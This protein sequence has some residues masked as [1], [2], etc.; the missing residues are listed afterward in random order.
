MR[1]V[2]RVVGEVLAVMVREEHEVERESSLLLKLMGFER[3]EIEVA[4]QALGPD[5][6]PEGKGVKLIIATHKHWEGAPSEWFL[7]SDETQVTFRND[8]SI[9]LVLFEVEDQPDAQSVRN[10]QVLHDGTVL[11]QASDGAGLK[12]RFLVVERCWRVAASNDAI[13]LPEDLFTVLEEIFHVVQKESGVLALRAWVAFV[14]K[15]CDALR[16]ERRAVSL[17]QIQEA[18]VR[19]LPHLHL[20]SDDGL[21]GGN[22]GQVQKRLVLNVRMAGM[23]APNG[24]ELDEEDLERRIAAAS[25]RNS[26]NVPLDESEQDDWRSKCRAVLSRRNSEEYSNVPLA[27]WEQIFAKEKESKVGLGTRIREHFSAAH[28]DRLSEYEDQ[29]L[30]TPLDQQ[31][32]VA[33]KALLDLEAEDAGQRPLID[34]LSKPLRKA[35]E[36]LASP[37]SPTVADPLVAVLRHLYSDAFQEYE[38][39]AFEQLELSAKEVAGGRSLYSLALFRFLYGRT[40]LEIVDDATGD[41][42]IPFRVD[43][44]LTGGRVDF[45]ELHRELY[46]ESQVG[47]DDEGSTSIDDEVEYQWEPL[48][49]QIVA[50]PGDQIL[51]RFSWNPQ[52]PGGPAGLIAFLRVVLNTEVSQVAASAGWSDLEDWC[53][54]LA[55]PRNGLSGDCPTPGLEGPV[56]D[57]MLLRAEAFKDWG[58]KGIDVDSLTNYVGR[59]QGLQDR[60]RAECIPAQ[61]IHPGLEGFLDME[62][63]RLGP[64]RV[65]LLASHPLRL[66]WVAEY[67]RWARI[68]LKD[69][70]CGNFKLNPEVDELFFGWLAEQSP[71]GQPPILCPGHQALSISTREYG[72]HEEYR[73]IV[74]DDSPSED[75]VSSID[76]ESVKALAAVVKRYVEAHPHKSDGLSVLFISRDGEAD[77]VEKLIKEVR[78]SGPERFV[79]TVHVV[80]PKSAHEEIVRR[81]EDLGD[82]D[83]SHENLLPQLRT[84]LHPIGI[85]DHPDRARDLGLDGQID[86]AIVPNLLGRKTAVNAR[87]QGP[88]AGEF[89]PLHDD[90]THDVGGEDG[91]RQN[92]ARAFLPDAGDALLEGWSSLQVWRKMWSRIG[93][94]DREQIDYFSLQVLF[95]ASAE[96]FAL[97]HDWSHWV[98]TLDPYVTRDQI[99]ASDRRP[100]II[101]VQPKVGKNGRYTLVVSSSTGRE[102]VVGRLQRRIVQALP[103]GSA[104]HAK[105]MA[106]RLYACGRDFAP[107][108]LLR[109]LGLGRTTQEILGLVVAREVVVERRPL[110]EDDVFEAWLSLDELAHWFGGP[111]RQRADLLRVVGKRANG[112]LALR[113]QIV[114]AKF[115]EYEHAGRG[116]SQLTRT[117]DVLLPA[118]ELVDEKAPYADGDHWRR[119]LLLAIEQCAGR[120]AGHPGTGGHYVRSHD[121]HGRLPDDVRAAI[122]EG[123]YLMDGMEAILCT[124]GAGDESLEDSEELTPQESHTWFRVGARGFRRVLLA[125]GEGAPVG[126]STESDRSIDGGE[127]ASLGSDAATSES[128][129]TEY[130]PGLPSSGS[131]DGG[132]LSGE[133][134][135]DEMGT[136]GRGLGAECLEGRFQQVLN[137]FS[138][139]KIPVERPE[140]YRPLEGP[141]F[142][143][144]RL[145]PGKGVRSDKIIG[146]TR[147][148]KLK[149]ELPEHLEIRGFV[150]RGSVVF[151]IPKED[152]ERYF[153]KTS[154]LWAS[155]DHPRVSQN[156]L[157]TPIGEN[158]KGDPVWLDFGDADSPHLLIGG[159]TGSGKSVALESILEGLC[160][161]HGPKLLRLLLIDPKGTELLGFEERAH[162]EGEIGMD[163]EDAI[164]VLQQGVDEMERRYK[165]FKG[166]KKEHGKAVRKIQEFNAVVTTDGI[167]PWK[168]IVLDEYADL[169][170]DKDSRQ[171]IEPLLQRIAQ[172]GRAAGIH[173]IVA[174]QKPSGEILSTAIRSNLPA[175]LALRVKTA[176]DSRIVMDETGAESLAGKGDAFLKTQRGIERVQTAQHDG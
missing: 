36:K 141:A 15:C 135:D 112:R 151:Q 111:H 78:S 55:D 174:T 27:I 128:P 66:R 76:G 157:K 73:S 88:R 37:R 45:V 132:S 145:K 57:W 127:P 130:E 108:V 119:E 79:L 19:S 13:P 25:F 175:Q 176:T 101:T 115:R 69:L 60:V 154:E 164:A 121:G 40:L 52:D 63:L 86:L 99:E 133:L 3:P 85:L 87:T 56:D 169:T 34:L 158:A 80:A 4:M 166:A 33:A 142:Y 116:E 97:M 21:F 173:L 75:W 1:L 9:D 126:T 117:L 160:A 48:R 107:G 16:A 172:K 95:T 82:E 162:L 159:T 150:D 68:Q 89:D 100:D 26:E 77:H 74:E 50:Q 24:K 140:E 44:V 152:A 67:L 136:A 138:E 30:Q 64:S 118:F 58:K 163:A 22:S 46:P 125:T 28:A 6:W 38:E 18:V 167:L 120:T 156:S 47:E 106:E 147:E 20:F 134:D 65:V 114:E 90:S 59:W 84:I 5:A 122:A 31:D 96:L 29:E 53:A 12:R 83:R 23:N 124:I 70:L 110:Q 131:G 104:E 137:L 103:S 148:L 35:V 62:T 54:H 171:S 92:V 155:C 94:G 153:I 123:R 81:L 43:E 51:A 98:V 7:G 144:V 165:L 11:E 146:Q 10:M 71:H 32:T 170:S 14:L 2:D 139:F 102:F 109:A 149:L 61:Q 49:L 42:L 91:G 8:R 168:L 161:A 39:G 41:Y 113:F 105:E 72:W 129:H 143:E 17:I 93:E